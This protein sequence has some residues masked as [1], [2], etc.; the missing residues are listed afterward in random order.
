[1]I[2]RQS[3]IRTFVRAGRPGFSLIEGTVA[4]VLL[5]VAM[6]TTVKALSWISRERQ[7]LDRRAI[8]LQEADNLLD[9]L[10]SRIDTPPTLSPE[11]EAALIDGSIMLER[12]IEASEGDGL[13]R[14]TVTVRY[15][16]RGGEPAAPV[17]LTT[18]I[19]LPLASSEGSR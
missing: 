18:W 7:A 16:D 6:S 14:L 9:R 8:A 4:V 10:T 12:S 19:A 5:I 3:V 1:M 13:E 17:R 2:R 11:A 15:R